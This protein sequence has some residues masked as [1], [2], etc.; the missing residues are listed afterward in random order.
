M[1]AATVTAIAGES[2]A[3]VGSIYHRFGSMDE[4]LAAVWTRAARRSQDLFL[5]HLQGRGSPRERAVSAG[6]AVYD[7]ATEHVADAR[8]LVSIRRE[9]LIA[10]VGDSEL[11]RELTTLNESLE[12]ELARLTRELYGR[13]TRQA[14]DRVRLG[15]VDLPLGAMR[16]HLLQGMPP[17]RALRPH[18][19][20][21][22]RAVL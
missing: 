1:R 9:D 21:A 10:G 12:S 18:L 4:L 11:K 22:I 16:R 17:P 7:F 2:G 8:L 14:L 13:A 3:P 6:L 19:G 20:E 5:G 15:V